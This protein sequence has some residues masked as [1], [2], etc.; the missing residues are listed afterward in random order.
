MDPPDARSP[1]TAG[2]PEALEGPR[3]TEVVAPLRP[4]LEED[5]H[6]EID[7]YGRRFGPVAASCAAMAFAASWVLLRVF[8]QPLVALAAFGSFAALAIAAKTA[9]GRNRRRGDRVID[10]IRDRPE[11]V[12]LIA[13]R[14]GRIVLALADGSAAAMRI[15]PASLRLAGVLGRRCPRARL[16]VA[17]VPAARALRRP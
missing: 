2:A 1:E 17:D 8:A 10:A 9:P 4:D 5:L 12:V 7:L 6:D 16:E 11:D 15:G 3:R 13:R 14:R